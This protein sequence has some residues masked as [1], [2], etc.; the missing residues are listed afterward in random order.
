MDPRKT[1][2]DEVSL[3]IP[4]TLTKILMSA[5]APRTFMRTPES[6][7]DMGAGAE[8]WA[9]GNQAWNGTRAVFSPKPN[10]KRTEQKKTSGLLV[11]SARKRE[12][13]AMLR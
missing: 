4:N 13:Y 6:I 12:M 2:S 9:S 1:R 10:M 11:P 3:S 5:Y 8:G 7:A